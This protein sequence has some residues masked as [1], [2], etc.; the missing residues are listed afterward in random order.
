[1]CTLNLSKI[2][3][4]ILVDKIVFLALMIVRIE[5]REMLKKPVR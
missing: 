2:N 1:M 4:N 3:W 5:T